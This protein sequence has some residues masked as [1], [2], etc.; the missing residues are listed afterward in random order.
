MRVLRF[1]HH[2]PVSAW[3]QRERE[4]IHGGVE[5]TLVSSR[6]WNEGGSMVELSP[7]GDDFIEPVRT[8]GQH[9]NLFVY[10][11]RPVWRLLGQRW[12][13]VD[14][15]EEPCS[16]A[17]AEVLA[18][19]RL[20]R[21][22]VPYVMYSAQN[23]R[24]RYPVPFR[25]TERWALRGASAAYVCNSAAGRI[26]KDKGLAAPAYDIPLGLDL[27]RFTPADR[28]PPRDGL[29]I[30][31]A[32]RLEPHKGVGVLLDAVAGEPAWRVE[33][34]GTG[35]Q[36]EALEAQAAALGAADR[37]R[38]HGHRA[39]EE[40]PAFYRGLDVLAVPSLETSGWVEQFGRVVVEAMACGV[41]VVASES[42]ALPDVVA[43]AGLLAPPGDAE[44]LHDRIRQ[45]VDPRTWQRC[46]DAGLAHA[47]GFTWAQVARH[48]RR[49]YDHA[50][51]TAATEGG[52]LPDLHV[53][54]V[55]YGP[56]DLLA[57]C[58]DRLG[59]A[60]PV[61][62]VDN[63]SSPATAEVVRAAGARYLDPGSN[64]G[65]ARGVN[66]GLRAIGDRDDDLAGTDVLLLNPDA[67]IDPAGV[68]ALH[69]ALH[70]DS[71]LAAVAPEQV[72]PETGEEVRVAWP[73]PSPMGAVVEAV[74]LG[75]RRNRPDFVIGSVLLLRGRAIANV[76]LLDERFFLYSEET[77]WQRRAMS[78]GWRSDVVR[79]VSG[80]HLGAA[81]SS[82]SVV[83]EQHF[84]ASLERY[85]RKHHGAAGWMVFRAAMVAGG[86]ARA[87]APTAGR[88]EA[89]RRRARLYVTGP[90]RAQERSR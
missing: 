77:D 70:T 88:R 68:T 28:K 34:A 1:A 4:L 71:R 19:R 48:H 90:V 57:A 32:G 87:V 51:P 18:L 13:L 46:R 37:V 35:S 52:G 56:P 43:G 82:D 50:T 67:G 30:G 15:H 12:D 36:R 69:H 79:G 3:R 11:P 45:L 33:V 65:F 41:P 61:T 81:T 76:G 24:K 58:L 8:F 84:H 38:F 62:V 66:H 21:S 5:L 85:V 16:L 73:F 22:R 80:T 2:A 39:A 83:R 60:F 29:T 78:R 6:R 53:I 54:V 14:L 75:L 72:H 59:G 31:Y 17:T 89:A 40:L 64:L 20:R 27:S 42:G 63:S 49:M 86:A 23:L 26:L 55:A 25:W 10:D 47:E 9:P 74:G 44:A 7:D